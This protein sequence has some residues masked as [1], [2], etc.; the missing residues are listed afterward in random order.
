MHDAESAL[1]LFLDSARGT[2]GL[3][4]VTASVLRTS[5][6]LAQASSTLRHNHLQGGGYYT[7]EAATVHGNLT[8]ALDAVHAATVLLE[9]SDTEAA[10]RRLLLMTGRSGVGKTHLFCDVATRRI[11]DGRPTLIALG[12]D[13]DDRNQLPQIGE[14]TQVEGTLEDVLKLLDA[15]GEAEGCMAM[16]MIDAINEGARANRWPGD[17]RVLARAVERHPHVTLAVSCRTEFMEPVVGE[18]NL[19]RIEHPGYAEATSEAVDRYTTEYGLERL[20]FPVLSP[21][22][23]NPLF[24]KLACEALST[25]GQD[26]FTLGAAGLAAVCDAFLEAVNARLSE[27]GRCDFD[28]SQHLVQAV[29]RRLVDLGP[30][31]YRRNDVVHVANEDILPGK[32]WSSSLYAGLVREG[33]LLETHDDGVVFGYQR[34]GDVLRAELIVDGQAD[35]IMNWYSSL[36]EDARWREQGVIAALAVIAPEQLDI[37]LIDIL[38]DQ[39][40]KVDGELVDAFLAGLCLRA[41]EGTTPRTAEIAGLIL[42]HPEDGNHYWAILLQV[43]C[44]PRH[45]VNADWLHRRL[46]AMLLPDR[47]LTWSVWLTDAYSGYTGQA[48]VK[49]VLDWAW[50][51]IPDD[52]PVPGE[53]V[54]LACLT[55]GWMLTVPDRVVR[56]R[57]TS[58]LVALGERNPTAF[59]EAVGAFRGCDDGYVVER[60]AAAVCAI[61]LRATDPSIVKAVADAAAELVADG[62]PLHLVTRDYL[63]RTAEAARPYGWKGPSWTSRYESEWPVDALTL[64]RIQELS[65]P[66]DYAYSSIWSSLSGM[67]GD[68]GTYIVKPALE[69]FDIADH[70]ELQASVRRVIF[71]RALE[72]GWTSERFKEVDRNRRRSGR[73]DA[74]VERFGKKYQWIGFFEVLGRLVDNFRLKDPWNDTAPPFD[75]DRLDQLVWR[76]IDP[77]NL[78]HAAPDESGDVDS[79]GTPRW[80]APRGAT[81]PDEVVADYPG[82]LDGVPDPLDLIALVNPAGEPWLA[83]HQ[84]ANWTQELAPE[85]AAL[86]AP[87]MNIW[88]QIRCYL[89]A[90]GNADALISWVC[91]GGGQDFDGRWMP[92]HSEVHNQLL[93]AHPKSPDWDYASGDTEPRGGGH[94]PPVTLKVPNGEYGGTGTGREANDVARGQ[95][96]SRL[97]YRILEIARGN[98]FVWFDAS[99]VAVKDFSAGSA[100]PSVLL[101]RRDLTK[102][103]SDAGYDLFWTVLL[104]KQR[105][106]A[107]WDTD[108]DNYRWVS[109]SASYIAEAEG[110]RLVSST[111]T[112]RSPGGTRAD[113]LVW[114]LRQKE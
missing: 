2:G 95:V 7:D 83:M 32:T 42:D 86:G 102:I 92:E 22:F 34:L 31:P 103:L 109:A 12:Q 43:A 26:R 13:F 23:D 47:D 69:H 8:K 104:N 44:V 38:K 57:A 111:A 105:H 99:G 97:L 35:G 75:Y 87:S 33:L 59:A 66:P 114:Q 30:G 20:S 11:A 41:P 113:R 46:S 49:A 88:M 28:R 15:A 29:G 58:G 36:G 50:P 45:T 6:V 100:G 112:R 40:G 94:G 17:L 21:E 25:L 16:L 77:T 3:L 93:A 71:T 89:V 110:L 52:R 106:D 4:E 61:A 73:Q 62:I 80:F 101:M 1:A 68:F 84:H 48:A 39:E 90:K 81:F 78:V 56:D 51:A 67:L 9:G 19:P 27:P 74:P 65:S 54:R 72:L 60:L 107:A 70:Q 63:R 5:A 76:D 79:Q 91:E 37:E 64:E 96:P 14:L 18:T 82:D 10:R 85:V 24:L 98:D 108:D 53:V 55:L